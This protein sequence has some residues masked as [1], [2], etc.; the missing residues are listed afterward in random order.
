M[1]GRIAGQRVK[2][3]KRIIILGSKGSL[4]HI[5]TRYLKDEDDY[6]VVGLNRQ[7]LNAEDY[8]ELGELIRRMNPYVLVNCIGILKPNSVDRFK[9]AKINTALPIILAHFA[10]RDGYKIIHI[11][12]NCVFGSGINCENDT[13]DATDLYG[14][15]KALGEINDKHNLTV[16]C[17]FAGPEL[18]NGVNLFNWF[19][20]K[21][22]KEIT[23]FTESWWNGVSSLQLSKFI[24]EC[25]R[26]KYTGLINYY[27]KHAVS[28]FQLLEIFRDVYGIKKV[29]TPDDKKGVHTALLSGNYFTTIPIKQQFTELKRWYTDKFGVP[30]WRFDEYGNKKEN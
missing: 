25:I 21:A 16:R 10:E 14:V 30:Y 6:E 18:K 20:N 29:I 19:A 28:K 7:D 23:G 8:T 26:N 1:V 11:S 2:R 24:E 17:S 9:N 15:S 22:D 13:P 5:L 4:G 27:S 3:K 12:S